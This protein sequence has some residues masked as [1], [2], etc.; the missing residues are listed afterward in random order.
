MVTETKRKY[1]IVDGPSKDTLFDSCKYACSKN[2]SRV[3]VDFRVAIGYTM[4]VNDP[5]C[6]YVPMAIKNIRIMGIEHE[7][8][9]GESFNLTGYCDANLESYRGTKEVDYKPYSFKAYYTSKRR[10]GFMVF[11]D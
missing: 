5:C 6:A 10:H 9:S 1:D 4:P 3:T 11:E 2:G 8:G 7:D